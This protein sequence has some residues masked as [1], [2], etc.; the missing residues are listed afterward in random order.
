LFATVL[1]SLSSIP[2]H[3][4]GVALGWSSCYGDG[5]VRNRAFACDSNIGDH[6]IVGSFVLDSDLTEVN[7]TEVVVGIRFGGETLP[8]WWQFRNAGSCRMASLTIAA[9]DG[10]NCPDMFLGQASMNIAAYQVGIPEPNMARI[11]SVNA[12]QTAL[13]VELMAAQE[14]AAFRLRINSQKTVGTG[15][16]EGCTTPA[17]ISLESIRV[18]RVGGSSVL[19]TDAAYEP[20]S[21]FLAWQMNPVPDPVPNPV[22]A[23]LDSG[24]FAVHTTVVG[25]G[26]VVRSRTKPLYPAGSP[27]TLIA[28]PLPGDRFVAW[29]GDT[30]STEDT[31]GI[32]V[33][34]ELNYFATFER[35]PVAAATLTSVS[36][37][38]NDQG[39]HVLATWNPSP[40]D[41]VIHAG[42]LCCYRVERTLSS[43]PAAP[44]VAAS[45]LIPVSHA[46]SYSL[47]LITPAD[48]TEG[49]P[50]LL[51]YR[52]IAIAVGNTGEWI[53]NELA[54]YSVDNIA[55]PPLASVSGVMASGIAT[56]F[57]TGVSVPD[58]AH[59]AVYRGLESEPPLDGAHRVG[60]TST[61]NY[62]DSPGHFAHYRVTVVDRHGNESPATPFIALNSVAVDGRAAPV[63]LTVGHP[64]PS[65]MRRSMT[66][67]L[68]LPRAMSATVDILDSQGRLVRRLCDGERAAGW[69]TIS[70]DARDSRGGASNPGIYFVRV[71]TPEGTTARRLALIP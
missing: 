34:R 64:S 24:G 45:G 65:P 58:F 21:K 50:A 7:S 11:L 5:G 19:L 36:D 52:V 38:S 47:D 39:G 27:L 15:A 49:D 44:W 67:S 43:A 35:D 48:S 23:G 62:T 9:F 54:G 69:A 33:Y 31:L 25:R 22:C 1:F 30:T 12:V 10:T 4:A 51:R 40:L 41:S 2:V 61:T 6:D 16:C 71:Q 59:Y 14:Y 57:W 3:A 55:P 68:G 26:E 42:L 29:S 63:S 70:W 13:A 60:T 18:N 66:L 46:S 37:V 8:A 28:V 32:V 56:L 17:C 20:E 53:S